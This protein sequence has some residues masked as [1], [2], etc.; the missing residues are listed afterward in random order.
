M[1]KIALALGYLVIAAYASVKEDCDDKFLIAKC[2]FGNN[3]YVVFREKAPTAPKKRKL[4]AQQD[5]EEEGAEV[6]EE[7]ENG[8]YPLMGGK[9]PA[10]KK[11]VEEEESASGSD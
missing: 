3:G 8:T 6:S 2:N 9:K 11:V 10:V 4:L 1:R 7:E 5:D